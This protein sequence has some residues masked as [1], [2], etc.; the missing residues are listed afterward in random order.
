P[1]S[2]TLRVA[3]T[4][5]GVTRNFEIPTQIETTPSRVSVAGRLTLNQT[6]FGIVPFSILGG[7]MQVQD[8]LDLRFRI[9]ANQ[10]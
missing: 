10:R 5:H 2:S 6:D 8:R 1:A 9:I 7:A 4:L 3:I